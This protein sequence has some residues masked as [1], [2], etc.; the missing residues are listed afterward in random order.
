MH[1]RPLQFKAMVSS[2]CFHMPDMIGQVFVR[3]REREVDF[4]PGGTNELLFLSFL[5]EDLRE[6]YVLGMME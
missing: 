1:P 6:P 4:G 5:V 3:G 2:I